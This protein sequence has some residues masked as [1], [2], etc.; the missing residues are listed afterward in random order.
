[1]NKCIKC[2]ITNSV[3]LVEHLDYVTGEEEE[4]WKRFLENFKT[5]I[6]TLNF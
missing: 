1:M 5:P 6:K 3:I 2:T 4:I